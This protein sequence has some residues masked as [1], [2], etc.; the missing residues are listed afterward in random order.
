MSEEWVPESERIGVASGESR[1]ERMARLFGGGGSATEVLSSA[2][3]G[4]KV[5]SAPRT[6]GMN[7]RSVTEGQSTTKI[8]TTPS[9]NSPT[10]EADGIRKPFLSIR[11]RSA[12]FNVASPGGAETAAA[13]L[14]RKGPSATPKTTAVS[15][16]NS[17]TTAGTASKNEATSVPFRHRSATTAT[18]SATKAQNRTTW[19]PPS[20]GVGDGGADG[21][22]YDTH[23]EKMAAMFGGSRDSTLH[24]DPPGLNTWVVDCRV[25]SCPC[26]RVCALIFFACEAGVDIDI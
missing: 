1:A 26:A 10:K 20:H 3:S 11:S 2:S 6:S 23:A 13:V 12:T 22:E 21:A 25:S 5:A 15:A 17:S 9:L 8:A 7:A 18:D 24:R 16:P 14:R 19:M 4:S